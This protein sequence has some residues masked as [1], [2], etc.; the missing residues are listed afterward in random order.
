M[1]RL[2]NDLAQCLRFYSRIP[3]PPLPGE[4]DA[5][6]V[7][8]FSRM[9]RVVP[10]GGVVIGACGAIVLAA[11]HAVGLGAPVAALV[12]LATLV[13]VT[14]AFHEDGLAD[15]ADSFGGASFERR[16]EIMTDSRIGSFG[17]SALILALLLRAALLTRLIEGGVGTACAVLLAAAAC[18]RTAALW[19]SVSLPPARRSGTAFIVGR[20]DGQAFA[21]A[22][23]VATLV[24]GIALLPS[25]GGLGWLLALLACAVVAAGARRLALRHVGGHTGDLAGATQQ[26][27]EIAFLAVTLMVAARG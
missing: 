22:I 9:A 3:V 24:A 26:C 13:L 7:P 19:L 2:L 18:S 25:I 4:R 6:A 14:G 20:P 15:S 5:Y 21:T 11:A 17:A 12:C 16:L 23:V 8:D 1:Q 10:L 27:T